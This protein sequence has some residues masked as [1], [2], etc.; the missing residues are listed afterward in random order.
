MA[1]HNKNLYDY[2]TPK[3]GNDEIGFLNIKGRIN[4]EVFFIRCMIALGIYGISYLIYTSAVNKGFGTRFDVLYDTLHTIILQT[5]LP[6]FVLIQGAKRMHDINLSGWH[7]LIPFYNLYLCFLPGTLGKN[8]FGLDPTPKKKIEF[9]DELEKKDTIQETTT[10]EFINNLENKIWKII[11]YLIAISLILFLLLI[12]YNENYLPKSA[13]WDGDG[14][15]NKTDKCM[16][17][18]GTLI[19]NGCPDQD[20]DGVIDKDDV[21]PTKYGSQSNG[22]PSN[23][24]KRKSSG[25]NYNQRNAYADSTK[26]LDSAKR[27]D[28]TKRLRKP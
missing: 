15:P 11:K 21:C 28:S 8:N 22:C 20:G 24:N 16:F 12:W 6:V 4:R 10:N 14:V 27:L 1:L 18:R 23:Y 19:T 17:E 5:L 2:K 13:D 3:S 25:N 26:R 7:F 9:F